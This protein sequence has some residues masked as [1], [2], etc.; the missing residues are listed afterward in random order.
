M[1]LT[2]DDESVWACPMPPNDP[3]GPWKADDMAREGVGGAR[4]E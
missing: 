1:R 2:P 3:G 4:L